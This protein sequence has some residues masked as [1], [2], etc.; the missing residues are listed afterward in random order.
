MDDEGPGDLGE[1]VEG[2]VEDDGAAVEDE[3]GRNMAALRATL[4]RLGVDDARDA[5]AALLVTLAARMD[6]G[7]FTAHDAQQYRLGIEALSRATVSV[8]SSKVDELR[9]RRE[10]R[11]RGAGGAEG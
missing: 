2:P 11:Q 5:T 4:T 10:R 7:K 6:S 1:D 9:S 3:Q 8:A